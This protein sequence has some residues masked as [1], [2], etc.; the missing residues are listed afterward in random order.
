VDDVAVNKAFFVGFDRTND[1]LTTIP[2]G[3]EG[4][5]EIVGL[6]IACVN[7]LAERWD[8]SEKEAIKRVSRVIK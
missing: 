5:A 3:H 1:L 2:K 4:E 8:M 6:F 7:E